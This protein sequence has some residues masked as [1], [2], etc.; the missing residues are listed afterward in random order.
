ME[1]T[2]TDLARAEVVMKALKRGKYDLE[3]E[4]VLA[5][6]QAF[7]WVA[8]LFGRIKTSLDTPP[9]VALPEP[10]KKRSKKEEPAA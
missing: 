5:F 8:E 10:I 7:H 4:E 1:V 2:K 6:A 9:P 3:G